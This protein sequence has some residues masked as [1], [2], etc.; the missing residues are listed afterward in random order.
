MRRLG[1]LFI[2]F[3]LAAFATD[4]SGKWTGSFEYISPEGESHAGNLVMTLT[5]TGSELTGTAGPD[6]GAPTALRNGKVD[7]DTVTFDIQ[8]EDAPLMHFELKWAGDHLK[9]EGKGEV[10][11]HVIKAKI[12]AT[13]KAE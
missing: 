11:G 6:D 2:L 1:F 3:V 10:E 4:F 13:R 5:Q 12:D 9:G 8:H 7:G